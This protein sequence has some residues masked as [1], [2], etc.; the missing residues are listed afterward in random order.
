MQ[1]HLQSCFLFQVFFWISPLSLAS[2]L[3]FIAPWGNG[4]N[5]QLLESSLQESW[6]NT[7]HSL[8]S[9]KLKSTLTKW[10]FHLTLCSVTSLQDEF[11]NG[12]FF[13]YKTLWE[14]CIK[15]TLSS[16]RKTSVFI[17]PCCLSSH[18]HDPLLWQHTLSGSFGKAQHCFST[19]L[20]YQFL[21]TQWLGNALAVVTVSFH[22]F[23]WLVLI[24][25]IRM[26]N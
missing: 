4:N 16:A 11:T 21:G 19:N 20:S 14:L 2:L 1:C 6:Q 22:V 18:L 9:S 26:E 8:F 23:A 24:S 13:Q 25:L 10:L 7:K 15:N 3:D 5:L 12:T 17:T